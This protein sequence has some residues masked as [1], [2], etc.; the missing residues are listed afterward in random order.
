MAQRKIALKKT[1]INQLERNREK[2]VVTMQSREGSNQMY[3]LLVILDFYD[4]F[5]NQMT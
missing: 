4:Y 1:N 2:I 5:P 3:Y